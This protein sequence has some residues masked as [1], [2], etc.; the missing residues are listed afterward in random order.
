M[1][2][3]VYFYFHQALVRLTQLF[4]VSSSH[5]LAGLK[6]TPSSYSHNKCWSSQHRRCFRKV[7]PQSVQLKSRTS[8]VNFRLF[9][10]IAQV[11]VAGFSLRISVSIR[12]IPCGI[13]GG[14]S[15]TGTNSCPN[16]SVY[17]CQYNS[18]IAQHSV[19]CTCCPLPEGR[20]VE[21]WEL[22]ILFRKS[23]SF[24]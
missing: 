23:V 17:S 12:A 3:H 7:P 1:W 13:C 11:L 21:A 24:V 10:A 19:S 6:Q 4:N 9:R 8:V 20:A 5:M 16:N 14:R 22:S 15:V 2:R 18:T